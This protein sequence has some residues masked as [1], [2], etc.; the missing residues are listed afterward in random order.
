MMLPTRVTFQPGTTA[1]LIFDKRS[2]LIDLQPGIVYDFLLSV[3]HTNPTLKRVVLRLNNAHIE[4]VHAGL[5]PY[6]PKGKH[7]KSCIGYCVGQADGETLLFASG[8]PSPSETQA[9]G[10][11]K[12]HLVFQGRLLPTKHKK[13]HP[14]QSLLAWSPVALQDSVEGITTPAHA[15]RT[16][17]SI[18]LQCPLPWL[19]DEDPVVIGQPVARFVRKVDPSKL[20]EYGYCFL[21][22]AI[23]L[24]FLDRVVKEVD[25]FPMDKWDPIP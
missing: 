16:F 25:T 6:V 9:C 5:D 21:D 3:F 7:D 15:S 18:P 14:G 2:V 22:K 19:G 4:K 11:T 20:D 12:A 1:G 24:E 23:S 13:L 10:F 8:K 17:V